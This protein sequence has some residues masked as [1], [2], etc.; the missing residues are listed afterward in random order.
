LEE[1]VLKGGNRRLLIECIK[2]REREGCSKKR[3]EREDFYRQ[4]GFSSKGIKTLRE[5]EKDIKG[6]IKRIEKDRMG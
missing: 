2:V 5:R 1:K 4:N 3:G 6:I